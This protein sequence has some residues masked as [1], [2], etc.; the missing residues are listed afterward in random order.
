MTR[1][2]ILGAAL[3]ALAACQSA[4]SINE[5]E[6]LNWACANDKEFSLRSVDAAIEIHAA[7]QTHRLEPAAGAQGAR[8]FSNGA[9]TYA[10]SGGRASLT[11]FHDGPYENCARQRSDWWPD[12]W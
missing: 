5:G 8:T 1:S 4:S 12:L 9:L 6:R 7:G 11:G 2:L 3:L 10:E